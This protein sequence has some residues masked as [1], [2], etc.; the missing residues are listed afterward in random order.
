MDVKKRFEE[1]HP[2]LLSDGRR[3]ASLRCAALSALDIVRCGLASDKVYVTCDGMTYT[4][5]DLVK[6]AAGPSCSS[7]G[8]T[9]MQR[10]TRLPAR[11]RQ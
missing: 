9:D 2:Y 7:D 8:H 10:F 4:F 1:V 3:F 5:R 6:V 11:A